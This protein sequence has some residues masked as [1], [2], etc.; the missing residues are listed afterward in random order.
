MLKEAGITQR[1]Q[2]AGGVVVLF[3]GWKKV[4]QTALVWEENQV[5]GQRKTGRMIGDVD[6]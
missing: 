4:W 2:S 6:G 5:A 1:G 3:E